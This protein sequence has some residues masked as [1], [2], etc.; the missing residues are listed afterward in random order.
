MSKETLADI[1]QRRRKLMTLPMSV[2]VPA[3]M[4]FKVQESA[5]SYAPAES[6]CPKDH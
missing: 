6:T 4:Y 5:R 3:S 1:E 2:D